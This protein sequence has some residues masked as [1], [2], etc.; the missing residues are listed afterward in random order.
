MEGLYQPQLTCGAGL[1]LD[2]LALTWS[3]EEPC[4]STPALVSLLGALGSATGLRSLRIN[5]V[6]LGKA[7]VLR[8]AS[9]LSQL[10]SI[11]ALHLGAIEGTPGHVSSGDSADSFVDGM[12]SM[13]I[14]WGPT[15]H[16]TNMHEQNAGA[17]W[18]PSVAKDLSF[19]QALEQVTAGGPF[20][21][22]CLSRSGSE[23]G[24]PLGALWTAVAQLPLLTVLSVNRCQLDAS[25]LQALVQG[26]QVRARVSMMI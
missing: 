10:T 3:D 11:S 23:D 25:Q 7:C 1:K 21:V 20:G 12:Q 5:G 4:Q 24:V 6:T 9:S 17:A 18:S 14:D 16:S 8:L 19:A 13:L 22:S 2:E 26:H 15:M